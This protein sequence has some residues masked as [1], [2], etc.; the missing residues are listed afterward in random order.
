MKKLIIYGAG[1]Q[2]RQFLTEIEH[3]GT[4]DP[5]ALTVDRDYLKEDRVFGLPVIAFE[6]LAQ[7][8]PED[9]DMLVIGAY[10]RQRLVENMYR[11]AKE[12]GYR[13]INY[14]SPQALID[15]EPVMGDNNIIYAGAFLGFDGQMGSGNIIRQQVYLGHEFR[16][17]NLNV[18]SPGCNIGG[19]VHVGDR[20]WI[21]LG[22]NVRDKISIGDDC[23]IGMGA[24]VVKSVESYAVATGVPARV[25]AYQQEKGVWL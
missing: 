15:V 9:Y 3:Y 11:K 25:V 7:Y 10:G 24:A 17:G 23:T 18:F 1:V 13:L 21:G 4:A 16:I 12:K 6:D 8:P 22:A 2:T 20:C 19:M 5:A 14:I